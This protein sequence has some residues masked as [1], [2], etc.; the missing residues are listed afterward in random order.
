M[1]FSATPKERIFDNPHFKEVLTRAKDQRLKPE[2]IVTLLWQIDVLT[3]NSK[4]LA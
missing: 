3:T 1:I 2:Q 4:T